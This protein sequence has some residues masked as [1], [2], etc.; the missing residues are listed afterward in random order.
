MKEALIVRLNI[1]EPPHAPALETIPAN[2][3]RLPGEEVRQALL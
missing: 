3:K 1:T 2:K